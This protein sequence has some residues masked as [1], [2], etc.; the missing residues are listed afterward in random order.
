MNICSKLFTNVVISV[1]LLIPSGLVKAQ[2]TTQLLNNLIKEDSVAV[3]ALALYPQNLR[4]QMLEACL[5][6]ESLV[7]IESLQKNTAENFKNILTSYSKDEQQKIWDLVR[8]PGLVLKIS[9]GEKKTTAQLETIAA[10]YP[11]EMRETILH[12]GQQHYDLVVRIHS[13]LMSNEKAFE[14]IIKEY[15]EKTK[16][17]LRELVKYPEAV[18]ILTTNMRMSVLAGDIY[19]KQPLLIQHKLDSISTEHA[20]QN[21]RDLEEW[22]TGLEKNPEA[23]KEMEASAREFAKE[24]GYN[25][26]DMQVDN[27]TIVV[28][29]VC[30][31]YPY[32]FGYPWWYNYPYWYPYPYWYDWGF[33]YGPYGIVYFG[34]PS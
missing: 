1:I 9:T 14:T 20:Q 11:S 27:V 26:E 5:Y 16:I 22:K 13:L 4:T 2:E 25:D 10:E 30:Q 17:A 31:P 23:K 28:N 12:C 19:K 33:Y 21:A 32:W 8:Y 29:Y 24:Q 15:P 34:Y 3:T 6:P 7:R 18:N